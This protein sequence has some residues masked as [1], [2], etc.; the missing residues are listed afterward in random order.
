LSIHYS[1]GLETKERQ[2]EMTLSEKITRLR[3]VSDTIAKTESDLRLMR[4]ERRELLA[5]LLGTSTKKK[6]KP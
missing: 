1:T 2:K 5:N 3:D 4:R 6:D